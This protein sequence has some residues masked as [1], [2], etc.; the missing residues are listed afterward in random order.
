MNFFIN[1]TILRSIGNKY[2][3]QVSRTLK[4]GKTFKKGLKYNQ[5]S[6]N[7]VFTSVCPHYY[8]VAMATLIVM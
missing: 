4:T 7:F 2:T 8:Y 1:L 6:Q 5:F 3:L